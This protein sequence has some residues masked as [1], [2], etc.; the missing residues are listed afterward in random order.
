MHEQNLGLEVGVWWNCL[1]DLELERK[2]IAMR[3]DLRFKWRW[4]RF[5][6]NVFLEFLI[7]K[8]N[9]CIDNEKTSKT[10][11]FKDTSNSNFLVRHSQH[12]QL[13]CQ[14]KSGWQVRNISLVLELYEILGKNFWIQIN[15]ACQTQFSLSSLPLTW[16]HPNVNSFFHV[17]ILE[18]AFVLFKPRLAV[19]Q[20]EVW[21]SCMNSLM[22]V[23][24]S[25]IGLKNL[26]LNFRIFTKL[27][28]ETQ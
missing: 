7:G 5:Y 17:R 1:K 14:V 18:D 23:K 6:E 13:H 27:S 19:L 3:R 4:W 22:D 28:H 10:C 20:P 16:T 25:N 12:N 2:L 26:A 8:F 15:N 11:I 9:F 24:A 21:D